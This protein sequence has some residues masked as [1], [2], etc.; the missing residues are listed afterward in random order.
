MK[1]TIKKQK[2][3]SKM[4]KIPQKMIYNFFEPTFEFHEFNTPLVKKIM[5]PFMSKY[6]LF[7]RRVMKS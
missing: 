1:K 6:Y 2:E 3:I 5:N 7:F 4:K